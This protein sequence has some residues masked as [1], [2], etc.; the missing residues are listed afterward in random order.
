MYAE[1]GLLQRL[2]H[3]LETVGILLKRKR[4]TVYL[5]PDLTDPDGCTKISGDIRICRI[6][7][8]TQKCGIAATG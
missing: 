2:I 5:D 3:L 4:L 8:R 7:V 6:Y 1:C